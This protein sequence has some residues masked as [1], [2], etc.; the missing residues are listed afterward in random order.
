MPPSATGTTIV[1]RV[2]LAD[3]H[4]LV[5]NALRLMLD[6]EPDIQVVAQTGSGTEG[7]DYGRQCYGYMGNQYTGFPVFIPSHALISIRLR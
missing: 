4:Q 1:L 7:N 5:R 2:L 6:S 3:D